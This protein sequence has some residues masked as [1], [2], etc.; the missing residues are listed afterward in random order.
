MKKKQ[1]DTVV[2][3]IYDKVELLGQN[4]A[5]DVTDEQIEDFG[6]YMKEADVIQKRKSPMAPMKRKSL[7]K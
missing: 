6:N 7:S 3:D 5:L 2:Q 1:L 4:K